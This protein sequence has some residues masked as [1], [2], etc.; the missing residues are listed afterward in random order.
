MGTNKRVLVWHPKVIKD[1]KMQRIADW[2]NGWADFNKYE[3]CLDNKITIGKGKNKR[4][5]HVTDFGRGY[6]KAVSDF[7]Q[8]LGLSSKLEKVKNK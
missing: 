4:N 3:E 6:E 5:N 8:K 1:K 2:V 7:Y